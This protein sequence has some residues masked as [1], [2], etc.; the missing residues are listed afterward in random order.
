M[1]GKAMEKTFHETPTFS[2][3]SID[4]I[5]AN[6]LQNR[7]TSPSPR[8]CDDHGDQYK[9]AVYYSFHLS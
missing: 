9:T 5:T 4:T 8:C 1:I 2:V 7:I 6:R 3:T